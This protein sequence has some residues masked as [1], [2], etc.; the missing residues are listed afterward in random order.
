M[1]P[2]DEFDAL[3]LIRNWGW[4]QR[5]DGSWYYPQTGDDRQFPS[6]TAE[7]LNDGQNK[8]WD[9]TTGQITDFHPDEEIQPTRVLE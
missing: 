1:T 8:V 7:F 9:P 4:E 5:P 6:R 3:D 2:D